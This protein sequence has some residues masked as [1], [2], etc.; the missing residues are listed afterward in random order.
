MFFRKGI[1]GGGQPNP[2]PLILPSV[3]VYLTQELS[4]LDFLV[5]EDDLLLVAG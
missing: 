1:F 5:T 2:H 3:N 4:F